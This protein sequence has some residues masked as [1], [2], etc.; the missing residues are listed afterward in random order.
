MKVQTLGGIG[1]GEL[2]LAL[3]RSAEEADELVLAE[4]AATRTTSAC[5]AAVLSAQQILEHPK[6]HEWCKSGTRAALR[7]SR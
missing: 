7:E 5:Y 2:Q 4:P 1:Q 6:Y 3:R